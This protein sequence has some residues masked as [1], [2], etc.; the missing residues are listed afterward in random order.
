[1]AAQRRRSVTVVH[2]MDTILQNLLGITLVLFM[3]G[4]LLEVGLKLRIREAIAALHNV[5]FVTLSLVWAFGLCPM[6]A[7]LLSRIVP[8]SEPYATGLILLGMTPCA[9]FFPTFAEKA[10]ADFGYVAAFVILASIGTIIFV[11]V[12]TPILLPGFKAD[13]WTIARP[14]VLYIAVPLVVGLLIRIGSEALA[15]RVHPLVKKI[16]VIVTLLML[17]LVLW[18]YGAE[19][20]QAVGTFAIGIQLLF[21]LMVAGC[22]Y[23]LAYGLPHSQKSVIALGI[24]TRNIGAAFAPAIAVPGLDK[25]V[26]VMITLAVPITLGCAALV[27]RVLARYAAKSSGSIVDPLAR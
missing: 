11:P 10:N 20:L 25:R 5:Q 22:S 6:L 8:L 16:T 12:A 7:L 13:V 9:P 2:A 17:A 1:M 24:C 19:F 3:V 15:D 23:V 26:I 21:Y 27:A 14:L 4:S 18:I